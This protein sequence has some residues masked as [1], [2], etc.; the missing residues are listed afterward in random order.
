M[1]DVAARSYLTAERVRVSHPRR[2]WLAIALFIGPVMTFFAVFIVYPVLASFYYSLHT[3]EPTGGQ[4]VT[5][6][7]GLKNFEQLLRDPIFGR[8][9][10]NTLIWATVGPALEM[11]TA[12]LLALLVYFRVPLFRFYRVAWFT[13]FLVSGVIVGLVFRWI[14]NY[15]WGLLNTFLRAISLDVLAVNWLGRRDTALGVVIFVHFWA[16]FGYS[17]VLLLA[18]LTAIPEELIEAARIDGANTRQAVWQIMLPILKPTFVTVLILS[19]IG[20]MQAFHVVWVLTNGGPL[21]SSETVATY[22]QKRAFAWN[23]LDLGYPSAMSVVWFGVV[24]VAVA[25]VSRWLRSRMDY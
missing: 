5:S 10:A 18:G 25:L 24:M 3:M 20:K 4:I 23:T 14:F 16:T 8:S 11:F 21:Y 12:T 1:T 13:P 15:D 17:F 19:L 7:V 22:V 6:F 9:V 2:P